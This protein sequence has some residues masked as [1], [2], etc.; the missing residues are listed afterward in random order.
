MKKYVFTGAVALFSLTSTAFG[1]DMEQSQVPSLIVNNF[2][3]KYPKAS[4]VEWERAGEAYKVEFETGA[5]RLDHDI[6][7]DKTGK[8]IRHKEEL[9]Q[10]DLPEAILSTINKDFPGYHMDDVHRVTESG[11]TKYLLDLES[12]ADEWEVVFDTKGN[13][14]SKIAD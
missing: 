6:W 11:S 7:Y 14:L 10:G 8:I 1:Q 4:D 13:V 9:L 3:L 2:Q 12:G 5:N